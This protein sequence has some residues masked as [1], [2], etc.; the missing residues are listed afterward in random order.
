VQDQHIY[1]LTIMFGI[2]TLK[3]PLFLFLQGANES[4]PLVEPHAA[5]TVA[6]EVKKEE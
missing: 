2:L 3:S 6:A 5:A 4:K 1:W